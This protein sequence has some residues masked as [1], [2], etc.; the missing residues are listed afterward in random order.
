MQPDDPVP[1]EAAGP[2]NPAANRC[3]PTS[4]NP[5]VLFENWAVFPRNRHGR[6]PKLEY[7]DS[8]QFAVPE[9]EGTLSS[10]RVHFWFA[11]GLVVAASMG[12][13]D[14]P[15]SF[16][17]EIRP[18]FENSCV[19]CH[20]AS[21]QL[22][23]LDLR[24]RESALKG[25][26]RR[27]SI[28]PG[29]AEDSRLYR[30]VAGIEK[31]SMPMDGK[32]TA[33]QIAAIKTWI[34]QGA[35]WDDAPPQ[36]KTAALAIEEMPISPEARRYWAFQKP[37]RAPVPSVDGQWSNPIDRFLEK[38]RREKGLHAAPLADK[39]TLVRRAYL[40]L[41]GLPP[42]AAETAAWLAD[43]SPQAWENLIDKLLASPHYGERW[44]RQ[45]GRA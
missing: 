32:L 18:V 42:T 3:T 26:V 7:T 23:K 43:D 45:I 36:T 29:K 22:S 5:F 35:Q 25:G 38:T 4:F 21:V 27:A 2:F 12:A 11:C 10:R 24:T 30:L 9:S 20:G 8:G 28:I 31:P 34:D 41:F 37:V 16:S 1:S 15:V 40:D 39:I 13:A 33:E 6:L 17:S 19:K 14:R 44:G